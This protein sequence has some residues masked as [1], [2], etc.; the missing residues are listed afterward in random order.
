MVLKTQNTQG[1]QSFT[2][3]QQR[4]QRTTQLLSFEKKTLLV[5]DTYDW[6]KK[7]WMRWAKLSVPKFL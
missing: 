7:Y 3:L 4:Q 5:A 6:N 2:L 1:L